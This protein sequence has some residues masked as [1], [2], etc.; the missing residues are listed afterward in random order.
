MSANSTRWLLVSRPVVGP[1]IDGGAA[2]LR[3]LIPALPPEPLDYFG[4]PRRPL[5]VTR[6]GDTL[7]RSPQLPA[8]WP[9]RGP[10]TCSSG[11]RS[12]RR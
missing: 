6:C 5:R 1:V 4:D 12:A 8:A 7:L 10:Q 2:L 11:P 9:T 3:E